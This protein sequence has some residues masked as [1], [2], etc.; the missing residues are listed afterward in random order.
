M[1]QISVVLSP[2]QGTFSLQEAETTLESHTL[3]NCRLQETVWCP[4]SADTYIYSPDPAPKAQ[5]SLQSSG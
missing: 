2:F 4:V 5:G 3:L 1:P